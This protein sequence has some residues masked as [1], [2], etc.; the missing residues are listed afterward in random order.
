VAS[1]LTLALLLIQ[2]ATELYPHL[3]RS[4]DP[5]HSLTLYNAA[6]SPR[7]LANLLIVAAIGVP[8]VSIYTTFVFVTFR[9][10]VHLDENSY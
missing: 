5:A 8:L 4:T 2:V 3:L 9:G 1:C 6:S 7:T 10:K